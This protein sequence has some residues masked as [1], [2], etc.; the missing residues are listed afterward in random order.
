MKFLKSLMKKILNMISKAYEA[1]LR[2]CEE[3]IRIERELSLAKLKAQSK[4]YYLPG[5]KL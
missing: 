5:D 2:S 1:F 3:S 4:F